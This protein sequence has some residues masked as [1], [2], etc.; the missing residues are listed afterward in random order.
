MKIRIVEKS[1][2]T[3]MA[4]T[5][6]QQTCRDISDLGCELEMVIFI[7]DSERNHEPHVHVQVRPKCD[8]GENSTPVFETCVRLDVAEYSLHSN[9]FRPFPSIEWLKLFIDLIQ[10]KSQRPREVAPMMA[11][12]RAVTRWNDSMSAN[13]WVSDDCDMPDYSTLLI[14]ETVLARVI[15]KLT[16]LSR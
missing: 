1:L 9:K 8:R 6:V 5:L 11:W 12:D 3:E 4:S 15:A 10:S 2:K 14:D 16:E 7:N 13:Y